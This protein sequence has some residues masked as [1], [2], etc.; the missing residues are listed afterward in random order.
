MAA[1]VY[2]A[3]TAATSV[4]AVP[5]LPVI[6]VPTIQCIYIYKRARERNETPN[7]TFTKSL[8]SLINKKKRCNF[9]WITFLLSVGI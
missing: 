5:A 7:V 3:D 4:D 1:N 8:K 6:A 9:E 2:F